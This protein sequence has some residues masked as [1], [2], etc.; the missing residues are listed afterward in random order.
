MRTHTEVHYCDAKVWIRKTKLKKQIAPSGPENQRNVF[1]QRKHEDV[2][3][4][5]VRK[6]LPIL[7]GGVMDIYCFELF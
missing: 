1:H 4:P 6:L 5:D 3:S 2:V 7:Y